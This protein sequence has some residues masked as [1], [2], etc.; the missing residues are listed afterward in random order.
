MVSGSTTKKMTEIH[1]DEL[2]SEIAD[3]ALE[4]TAENGIDLLIK[5]AQDEYDKTKE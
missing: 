4:K 5:Q 1:D 2:K 3:E